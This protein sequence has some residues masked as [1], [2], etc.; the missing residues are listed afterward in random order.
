MCVYVEAVLDPTG[1]R[2]MTHVEWKR[3]RIPPIRVGKMYVCT[4][5]RSRTPLRWEGRAYVCVC[6]SRK[7]KSL[8]LKY[9]VFYIS[10]ITAALTA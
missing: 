3:S 1:V 2:R 8:L 4:W 9:S 6:T 5:K 7:P 10:Y